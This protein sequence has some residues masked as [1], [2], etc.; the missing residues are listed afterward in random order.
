MF[1]LQVGQLSEHTGED[2]LLLTASVA[3][4]SLSH[5]GS[6]SGKVFLDT[7]DDIKT[8]F[9]GFCLNS[10]YLFKLIL[11]NIYMRNG[12]A[13]DYHLGESTFIFKS[14]RSDQE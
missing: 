7:H 3:D 14:T 8:Q 9:L 13:H 2:S 5:I 6:E 10:M 11:I 1:T 4:G 12:L